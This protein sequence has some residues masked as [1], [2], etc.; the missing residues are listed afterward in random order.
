MPVEHDEDVKKDVPKLTPK[1][2]SDDPAAQKEE[3]GFGD[4]NLAELAKITKDKKQQKHK[5]KEKTI[6]LER[7]WLGQFF[8]YG[9]EKSGN[10]AG[11]VLV[12]FSILLAIALLYLIVT[13]D[14]KLLKIII[15][16]IVSIITL[17]LGY[18]FGSNNK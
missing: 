5:H 4:D 18:L 13:G 3:R 15:T 9:G 16:S 11:A 10:I 1:Y 14:E 8:G 7:G 6:L 17:I 2:Q 12:L